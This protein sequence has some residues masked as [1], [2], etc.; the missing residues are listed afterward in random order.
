[1]SLGPR[2]NTRE[3]LQLSTP[4]G[5]TDVLLIF[6]IVFCRELQILHISQHGIPVITAHHV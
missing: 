6:L 5:L 1:M 2:H 4:H 3:F